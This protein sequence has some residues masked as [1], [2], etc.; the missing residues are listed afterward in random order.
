MIVFLMMLLVG[1]VML[2][3][4][5]FLGILFLG[6]CAHVKSELQYNKAQRAINKRNKDWY[7][8]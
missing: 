4:V 8:K 7:G 3:V 2:F 5:G 1:A 6:F